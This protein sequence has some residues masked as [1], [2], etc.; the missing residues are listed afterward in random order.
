[1]S[2]ATM[3][4][5]LKLDWSCCHMATVMCNSGFQWKHPRHI[6]WNTA[7]PS[8]LSVFPL[9]LPM[10]VIRV[11]LYKGTT[12]SLVTVAVL[13]TFSTYTVCPHV[14][15]ARLFSC[16]TMRHMS[17]LHASLGRTRITVTRAR[18]ASCVCACMQARGCSVF[19]GIFFFLNAIKSPNPQ[20]LL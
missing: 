10:C 5:T 17:L 1:M 4:K 8:L 14:V 6:N 7:L 19:S 2:L 12:V 15:R 11:P 13:V 20:D 3:L 16:P 9:S 18:S